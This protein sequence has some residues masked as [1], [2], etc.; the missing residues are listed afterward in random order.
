MG[1]FQ[2][3]G[4]RQVINASGKMTALGASAVHPAV[5]AVLAAAAGDY[6]VIDELYAAAG[7]RIAQATGAEFAVPTI[8]AASGIAIS[9]AACIAGTDIG[10]IE[11]LPLSDGRPNEI[12]LPKGHAVHFG[13]SVVQM[14]RLGGGVPVEAGHAN[15]VTAAHI[16]S[17]I[18]ERT[19]ALFYCKSHHAV[20]KG[21]VS[22]AEMI[23][24]GQRLGIPVIVDAA[25]EEDLRKYV[26]MGADL[27][28]YSGG[29]AIG[30]P[31]SGFIC[32]K[33]A[34]VEACVMQYKGVGRAMKVSKEAVAGLLAAIE[35]YEKRDLHAEAQ[36]DKARM[37]WLVEQLAGVP[38]VKARLTRD[39]AGREI[40]RASVEILPESGKTA[41]EIVKALEAGDPAI[42]TRNHQVNLGII[43]I[44]PRPM[45]P[46]QEK[47]LLERLLA[48]LKEG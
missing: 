44:D 27:V 30:G 43:N 48:I 39:E 12:V 31:T 46:G 26:A 1:Q 29:K 40:Y 28:L 3:W 20:Q 25:A 13:G 2:T 10:A 35:R 18:T 37:E 5:G 34:L 4:L 47:I 21:M 24:I 15:L 41:A 19:A 11:R 45:L 8:G 17:A 9:V 32:G 42:Y 14:M 22:L 16:E 38:G 23:Q 7:E 6:V 33:R 36:R